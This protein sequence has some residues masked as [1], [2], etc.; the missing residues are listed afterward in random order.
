MAS[1]G[2]RFKL[3]FSIEQLVSLKTVDLAASMYIVYN[4]LDSVAVDLSQ[5]Q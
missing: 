3:D 4:K 5:G 2:G 1:A